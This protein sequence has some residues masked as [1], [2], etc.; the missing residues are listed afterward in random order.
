ML[1]IVIGIEDTPLKLYLG[2]WKLAPRLE[3]MPILMLTG[4]NP[5]LIIG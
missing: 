3:V 2:S 1:D 5:L 4:L